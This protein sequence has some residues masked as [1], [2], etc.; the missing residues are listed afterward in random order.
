MEEK[1]ITSGNNTFSIIK[2]FVQYHYLFL[3]IGLVFGLILV[4]VNPPWHTNDEDRHF[5]NSYALSQG[6]IGP[7]VKDGKIGCLMPKNLIE[8]VKLHQ[9]IQFSGGEYIKK[10]NLQELVDQPLEAN[11]IEFCENVNSVTLP[12]AYLP[13]ALTIK[14]GMLFN[15]SSIWL[16]WWARIGSLLAY[17]II[18][19][20]AIKIIPHFK[21]LLML[22]ALSPMALY[23]GTSVTYDSLSFAFLFLL[24][25]LVIKYYYQTTL[26]TFKQV[27]LF[28]IIALLQT[29]CK[30]GYFIVYFSLFAISIKKFT[31]KSLYMST[32]FLLILAVFLPS[33]LWNSYLSTLTYPGAPLQTDFL[34]NS[35][36]NL[37]YQLKD[38][39][40]LVG[41][42][43]QNIFD[44]GKL[45]MSGTVG[46]FGY[47]YTLL[48]DW[49]IFLQLL[50]CS[51][52]VFYE[53][54]KAPLSSKFKL[55][56]LIISV[57]NALALIF[58]MLIVGSPV[59]ANMIYGFQ[60]RYF[61]PLLPFL[62]L[63]IFY[64]PLFKG[65]EAMMR[66][67]VPV[68]C[69]LVLCYTVNFIDSQF[70]Y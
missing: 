2:H 14:V 42:I 70:Y 62:F 20:F 34:F 58:G 50:V 16:G 61:T 52:V 6:Y 69:S 32:F 64:V 23:Q 19:F 54:P 31:S 49:I 53:K 47:S 60:G 5:Y 66:W 65:Q 22:V 26:I 15:S 17:L 3:F 33:Y 29:S 46:R 9:A 21:P 12:F 63:T 28:F 1:S 37:K 35:D 10:E 40:H 8:A 59:G 38:P 43:I 7:Q 68:Y 51:L 24:F 45:W 27:L 67:A 56:L 55:T 18:V 36:L 25:A 13:S 48:P 44:Q 41:I 39:L 4:F 11:K 30:D 57:L